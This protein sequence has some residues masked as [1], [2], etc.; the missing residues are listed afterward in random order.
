MKVTKLDEE[1]FVRE[2]YEGPLGE[3]IIAEDTILFGLLI[4]SPVQVY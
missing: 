2:K 4:K 1:T 3:G